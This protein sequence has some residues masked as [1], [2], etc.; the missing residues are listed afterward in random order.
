MYLIP[1]IPAQA[2]YVLYFS[3]ESYTEKLQMDDLVQQT[4]H[5]GGQRWAS[6]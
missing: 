5:S 3:S 6:P 1:H 2:L 4:S